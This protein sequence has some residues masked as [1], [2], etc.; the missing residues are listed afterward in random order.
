MDVGLE[1]HGAVGDGTVTQRSVPT[2][3]PALSGVVAIAAGD[4]HTVV[5]T[6]SG[7]LGVGDRER[8]RATRAT[9]ISRRSGQARSWC[10]A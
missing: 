3:V 10:R 5:R 7:D 4:F 1:Q 6:T 8:R 9:G 2:Q